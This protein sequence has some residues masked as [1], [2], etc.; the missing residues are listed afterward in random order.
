MIDAALRCAAADLL[1]DYARRLDEDRLEDW[2]DL[3]D[4]GAGYRI[5]TRENESRGLPLPLMLCENKAMLADRVVSLRNANIYNIHFDRHV[6]GLPLLSAAADGGLA[7]EA[8]FAVYQ[9][10]VEGRS[11]LF[12]VGCYRSRL[13]G[14]ADALRFR[15]QTVLLDTAAIPTLLSTPL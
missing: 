4:E 1:A 13:G 9:T 6:V 7:L 15:D 11:R 5:L 10:D 12:A 8:G 2:L 14:P 3:F